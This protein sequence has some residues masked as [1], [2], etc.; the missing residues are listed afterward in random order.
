[1]RVARV[2]ARLCGLHGAVVEDVDLDGGDV[3]VV[4][5]RPRA[6]ER[7]RCGRCGRRS[8]GYDRGEGR[9]RWRA[10]DLGTIQTYV[11]AEAPRVRCLEHG[12]VVARVPWARYGAWHTRD[13]EDQAAWLATQCSKSA[14]TRLVRISWRG[15]GGIITRVV[16]DRRTRIADPLE[17]L[18]RI[19]IDEISVRRGRRYIMGVIDHDTGRL[20]WAAEGRDS[21][22]L[23]EFFTL[24]G[25]ARCERIA[26]VSCDLGGWI[27]SALATHC[28]GATVCMD[29]FHVTALAPD[30]LDEVR[31]EVWNAARRAKDIAGARWLKGARWAL[32]KAPERLTGRQQATLSQIQRTNRPAPLPRL[33]AQGAAAGGLPRAEQRRGDRDARRMGRM[34]PALAPAELRE[35]GRHHPRR[36]PG[37]RGDPRPSP[38]ERADRGS[39][40][41]HSPDHPSRLRV[42]E[43]ERPDLAGDAHP[44]RPL[45]APSRPTSYVTDPRKRQES[46]NLDRA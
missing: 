35:A 22:V 41:D 1:M 13:F 15:V 27:R 10:L 7:D 23:G 9:R 6:A 36:P 40:H 33:S 34:G 32:W 20:V 4:H 38:V 28:P 42:H 30:A 17:G 11:E 45:P 26:L 25:H 21:R 24:L 12:V 16:A 19:G 3:I 37:H 18:T 43:R 29:P 8:P 5:A 46:L 31:R 39:Q 2:F 14:I 44:R